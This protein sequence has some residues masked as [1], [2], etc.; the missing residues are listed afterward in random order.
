MAKLQLI[1]ACLDQQ[2]DAA[3]VN[4]GNAIAGSTGADDAAH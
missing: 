4:A 2:I 3:C 1:V